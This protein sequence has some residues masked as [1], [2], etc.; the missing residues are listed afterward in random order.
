MRECRH[1]RLEQPLFDFE[2]SQKGIRFVCKKCRA[3]GKRVGFQK[4]NVK[5][6]KYKYSSIKRGYDFSLT[7]EE[8]LTFWNKPC[9]YCGDSIITIG[10]DRI[11]NMK[12]YSINNCVPCCKVCNGMKLNYSQDFWITHMKKI[13]NKTENN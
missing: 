8:F 6:S 13:I 10:I 7:M 11:D 12:G 4:H 1:C 2:K 3:L 5:Y 9:S